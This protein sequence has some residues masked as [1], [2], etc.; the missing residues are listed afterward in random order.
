M[1]GRQTGHRPNSGIS[2]RA[3]LYA[4]AVGAGTALFTA[5]TPEGSHDAEPSRPKA[6]VGKGSQTKPL[7]VP[8]RFHEAPDL[9]EMVKAGTLPPVEERLPAR[10][11]VVPHNWLERGKYGGTLRLLIDN[12]A[13][14]VMK[15]YMYGH[16]PLR[17]LNDAVDVGPGLAESWEANADQSEWTLHFR[18]G[19]RWS[20]GHPCTTADVMFWWEDMVLDENHPEVAP[21]ELRSARG[22]LATLSA[23]DELTLVIGFDT[24]A[25]LTLFHL[26]N[27]VKA[28]VGP[29]WIAPKHYLRRFHPRYT[30]GLGE[31]WAETFEQRRNFAVNPECPTLTGWRLSSYSEGRAMTWERNP[32]YWC[33]SPEGDQLPY[34][35]RINVTAVDDREVAKLKVQEGE[36]DYVHG[37]FIG[38][39]LGDVSTLQRTRTRHRLD[40]LLWNSGSGCGSLF[41]FNLNYK[42][43][44]VR[45]VLNEPKFR[46]ALSHA[47]D[48]SEIQK[49]VFFDT[50]VKTTGTYRFQATDATADPEGRQVFERWRDSYVAYDTAK[51]KKLL[52]EIGVVDSD[53]D[54]VRELPDGSPLRI[55][56]D[57]T[58]DAPRD[59]HQIADFFVKYWRAIGLDVVRNPVP[60]AQWSVKWQAGEL[61]SYTAWLYPSM[62]VHE[63]MVSP[64]LLV[65]VGN[66]LSAAFWA[67]LYANYDMIRNTDQEK[68]VAEVAPYDRKPP[69][70]RPPPGDPVERLWRLYDQA[71]VETDT[72]KRYQLVWEMI[73]IHI[74]E[75]PFYMGLVADSPVVAMAHEDL[76]NVPRPENLHVGG[77]ICP[78]QHPTPAAYDPEAFFWRNPQDH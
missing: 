74:A 52:D 21:A 18:E 13:S 14:A 40:L 5:C 63:C 25:P 2:R 11:Y 65:P 24:S 58:A 1:G 12:T 28:G 54:G 51:A 68:E 71:K 17:W 41:F 64:E 49:A 50:G 70:M 7:P 61:M 34:I 46:Q 78:W 53:G 16:S 76:G 23:P 60:P 62:P 73:K 19:L 72:L 59:G 69:S 22:T 4:S 35:D 9:A 27:W 32:Y 33:V 55:R 77:L 20:D 45:R 56:L 15:E 75:G 43:E 3:F 67:P 10:P 8:P 6:K 30:D 31:A 37:P 36:T 57:Q 44:P 48:R 47:I 38:L 42:D 29:T 26:A 39:G 66:A